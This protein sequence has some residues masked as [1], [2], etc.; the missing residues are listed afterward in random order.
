LAPTAEAVEL[1]RRHRRPV[2]HPALSAIERIN[3][4]SFSLELEEQFDPAGP[5]GT[6]VGSP[7]E[8]EAFLERATPES[9]WVLKA[10]HGN[11]GLGN[12]RLRQPRL[13]S[14]DRRFVEGLLAEDDRLV[15]EPWLERLRDWCVVFSAPFGPSGTRVHETICT[16]DGALIG[17]LFEPRGP[18]DMR[19]ASELTE[20][21]RRVA[22]KLEVEGYFGPVCMDAFSWRD[23]DEIKL[24]PLADLNCRRSMSDGAYRMWDRLG[25]GITLYYRF[26]NR[27]KLRLAAEIDEAAAALG[28]NRFDAARHRG[29]LFASPLDFTKI[30][31][32]FVGS[33]RAD[34]FAL[35]RSF[36]ERFEA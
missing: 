16:R 14:A 11:S 27:R 21:A 3:A 19:W 7:A 8:L 5:L 25:P 10:E 13:A 4:R 36:R 12:R 9:E 18:A 32:V 24:R 23:G 17:A 30:A 15:I 20:T 33:D 29:V 34:V 31:V 6:L 22:S 2:E 35:E 1:N 26:F 28:E